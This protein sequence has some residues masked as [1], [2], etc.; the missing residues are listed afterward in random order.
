MKEYKYIC[1][2]IPSGKNISSSFKELDDK[3]ALWV[4]NHWNSQMPGTYQ[5]YMELNQISR[6]EGL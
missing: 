6:P 1:M 3:R 2:H 4:I 5:Y